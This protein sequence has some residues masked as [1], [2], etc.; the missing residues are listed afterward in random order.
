MAT[1]KTGPTYQCE[2]CG[3]EGARSVPCSENNHER[4]HLNHM[5]C[6]DCIEA[7][8]G[9]RNKRYGVIPGNKVERRFLGITPSPIR[10]PNQQDAT[11]TPTE[12]TE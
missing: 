11:P 12:A 7:L 10:C 1:R 8:G 4:A 2:R 6:G 3:N 9:E 5:L